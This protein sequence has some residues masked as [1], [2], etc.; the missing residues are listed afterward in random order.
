MSPPESFQAKCLILRA[1]RERGLAAYFFCFS[2]TETDSVWKHNI[3]SR[4]INKRSNSNPGIAAK[5]VRRKKDNQLRWS[6]NHPAE[7][8]KIVRGSDINALNRAY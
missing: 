7:A 4:R 1:K 3:L 6:A 5:V 8:D 2:G